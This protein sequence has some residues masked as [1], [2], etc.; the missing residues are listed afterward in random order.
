MPIL[1]NPTIWPDM[2]SVLQEPNLYS[3]KIL[4]KVFLLAL[5]I[6]IVISCSDEE[7]SNEIIYEVRVTNADSADLIDLKVIF[8]EQRIERELLRPGETT[9][10]LTFTR[11][12][13]PE[14]IKA[15]VDGQSLEVKQEA[16]FDL[17]VTS[18]HRLIY[19]YQLKRD[20]NGE[21]TFS[22]EN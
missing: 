21:L 6:T 17:F 15:T 5:A 22:I 19:I 4:P 20:D 7:E 14:S 2:K 16:F 18:S 10:T 11:D 13:Y 12:Y 9:E 8:G 3:M 1:Y